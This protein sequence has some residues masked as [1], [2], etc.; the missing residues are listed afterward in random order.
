MAR[1]WRARDLGTWL[2]AVSGTPEAGRPLLLFRF[3]EITGV[4]VTELGSGKNR[5]DTRDED[6]LV[7]E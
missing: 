7:V 5:K 3:V 6:V 1:R 4:R 2:K